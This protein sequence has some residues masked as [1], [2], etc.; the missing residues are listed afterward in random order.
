MIKI[1]I[2][3]DNADTKDDTNFLVTLSKG[4]ETLFMF[5]L[6]ATDF[7]R[8]GTFLAESHINGMSPMGPSILQPLIPLLT[9]Q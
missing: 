4:K 3:H 2:A 6:P 5:S 9:F 1:I 8:V 7:R